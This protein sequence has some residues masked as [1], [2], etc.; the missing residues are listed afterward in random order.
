MK[1]KKL[2]ILYYRIASA[3]KCL[4]AKKWAVITSKKGHMQQVGTLDIRIIWAT[5]SLW[6]LDNNGKRDKA[7]VDARA[8]M[9]IALMKAER[10]EMTAWREDGTMECLSS[11]KLKK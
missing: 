7:E 2:E 6:A 3:W 10:I 8:D 5:V 1:E 11:T 9:L 4:R